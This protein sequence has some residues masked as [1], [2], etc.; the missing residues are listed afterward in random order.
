MSVLQELRFALRAL[1]RSP[2]FTLTA[3]AMLSVGLG[4]CMYMFGAIQSFAMRPPPY[5]NGERLLHIEYGST[6]SNDDSI[7]LPLPDYLAMREAQT[8]LESLEAFSSGTVNLSGNDRPERYNGAFVSPGTFHTLGVEPLLGRAFEAG[9]DVPGA[10]PK[11]LIGHAVWTERYAADPDIVGKVVRA[12][13]RE[14]IVVGVMP[15]GFA[16][17]FVNDVWLPLQARL[18]GTPRREADGVEVFGLPREGVSATQ[19]AQELDALLS[20]L[21]AADPDSDFADRTIVKSFHAEFYSEETRLVVNTMFVSVLLVLAIACAN[22]ANLMVARSARRARETAI[23]SAVGATRMRL[24]VAG[25][26]EALLVCLLAAAVGFVLA[27]V[28]GEITMQALRGSE[29]PPPYWMTEFRV[30][31]LSVGFALGVALLATLLAGLWPAWRA[32]RGADGQSMREGGHGATGGSQRVG[33]VLTTME[34]ALCMV[35]LV[36]AGL[37]V[38]SVIEHQAMDVPLDTGN[39]L[40]GRLGLFEAAYPDDAALLRF[41]DELRRELEAVPG[42]EQASI[43]N[44]VPFSVSN[45][46]QLEPEGMVVTA[47]EPL[48]YQVTVSADPG[49]FP[50]LGI[51]LLRGRLFDE[52]DGAGSDRVAIVSPETAERLW[53]GQDPLG[54]RFRLGRSDQAERPWVTVVGVVP[55][56]PQVGEQAVE[57]ALYLPFAQAPSRFFH[58]AVR[59]ATEPYA[60]ADAVRGAV[61]RVDQDLPVYWLRSLDDWIHIAGF[62]QRLLAVLFGMFGVFAVLLAAAGL[63][64]VLAYQ[65]NQRTR[66]IG[67]RRALGADNRGIVGLVL[68]QGAWQLGIGVAVGLVLALGFARLLAS[69]LFGVSPHDPLTFA[70]VIGLLATVALLSAMVPTTRALRVAPMSALR[71]D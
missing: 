47:G 59:T 2:W 33:R 13:G 1:R 5:A 53:P 25:V 6:V 39:V 37:T 15:Q 9:D 67:V 48:P 23:R 14:A 17:P 68:R 56:V 69:F 24:V 10:Q 63:Y 62:D 49:Y 61:L 4:L 40:T 18:D 22:V 65:V 20:R 32:A 52:R 12:N 11:L 35:L 58:F 8:S 45:W 29:D 21:N 41:A 19:V 34:I 57:P 3:V 16:F 55:H 46:Q 54:K 7:E 27:Q 50:L 66:E 51:P 36:T 43:T 28:G 42:V 30:D 26:G 60:Q 64:A 38:R 71:Q 44:S 70:L 31:A